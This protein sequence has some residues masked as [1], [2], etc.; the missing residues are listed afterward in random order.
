VARRLRLILEKLEPNQIDVAL[1]EID[2]RFELPA[3]RTYQSS[4]STQVLIDI[5][6]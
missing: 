3:L 6:Q 5:E 2:L 1:Q 4:D